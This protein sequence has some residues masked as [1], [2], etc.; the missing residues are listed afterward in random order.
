MTSLGYSR[1]VYPGSKLNDPLLYIIIKLRMFVYL[2]EIW[3][4]KGQNARNVQN[5]AKY[6]Y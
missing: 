5:Y 6:L 4:C 1:N 3:V 2:W